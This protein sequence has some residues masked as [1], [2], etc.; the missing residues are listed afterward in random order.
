ML[1]AESFGI[2]SIAQAA[3][4]MHSDFLRQW[5]NIPPARHVVC[6][7]SFGYGD[8]GHPANAFRT[9]RAEPGSII[10]WIEG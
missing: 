7:I 10:R 2:A 1:V 9:Y 8:E 4:A 5:F 3:L 6:G